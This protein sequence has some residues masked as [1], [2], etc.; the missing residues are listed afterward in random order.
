[1]EHI[2]ELEGEFLELRGKVRKLIRLTRSEKY[3]ELNEV[4]KNLLHTRLIHM[5]NYLSTLQNQLVYESGLH[6]VPIR[7]LL[8]GQV[9][10]DD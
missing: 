1:M 7:I 9:E 6:N 5:G 2:R 4:Q 8:E 10:F 3:S